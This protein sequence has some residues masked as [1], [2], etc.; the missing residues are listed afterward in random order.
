M[1]LVKKGHYSAQLCNIIIKVADT[2]KQ[3]K[4]WQAKAGQFPVSGKAAV[5]L[6][7]MLASTAAAE[8]NWSAWGRTS[9]SCATGS[10]FVFL[11]A[12]TNGS[13]S[14]HSTEVAL[15]QMADD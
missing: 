15:A 9:H 5:P 6:L 2:A 3:I 1:G 7:S 14:G 12:N 13:T 11:K 10:A 8:C 4:F